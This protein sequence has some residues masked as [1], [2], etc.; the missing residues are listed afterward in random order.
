MRAAG[1]RAEAKGLGE[2]ACAAAERHNPAR[3]SSIAAV[4]HFRKSD[5]FNFP[6]IPR[7]SVCTQFLYQLPSKLPSS[8]LPTASTE[9]NMY[10]NKALFLQ[11]P[12]EHLARNLLTG[13]WLLEGRQF[14]GTRRVTAAFSILGSR[15]LG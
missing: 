9:Y 14:S 2:P 13:G 7:Q 1:M 15:F 3:N 11:G 8:V 12:H 4:A 10:E 5:F 6:S